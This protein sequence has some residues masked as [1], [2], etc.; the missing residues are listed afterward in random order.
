MSMRR[1]LISL[2]FFAALV[3]PGASV[4]AQ[5]FLANSGDWSAF[6]DGAGASLTCYIASAPIKETGNYQKRGDALVLVTHRPGEKSRDV[7]EFRAGYTY[8]KDSEVLVNIDGQV[9][10]LFTDKEAAWAKDSKTDRSLTR[11][12]I[13]G[14]SM[15]VT[16]FSSRGTKT[17]D[18]YSLKGFTAAYRTI[19]KACG[20]K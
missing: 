7:V 3:L 12:M 20:V 17:V 19:G 10:K 4:S 2:T 9:Y 15:V 8:R 18:T 13:R 1:L 6:K 14:R 16:G 5:S 11:A